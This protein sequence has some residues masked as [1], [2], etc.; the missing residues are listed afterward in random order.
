MTADI[1][2]KVRERIAYDDAD[3]TV[4]E[5]LA[6]CVDCQRWAN[7]LDG[8]RSA[9]AD[10][11]TEHPTDAH[12]VD[13]IALAV[14][15]ATRSRQRRRVAG[16]AS[17][18]AVTV[19]A[20]GVATLASRDSA[21]D[22]LAAAADLY[23]EDGTRFVFEASATVAL[24]ERGTVGDLQPVV[25]R[26]FPVCATEPSPS[27]EFPTGADLGDMVDELL[28]AEPC[29]ALSGLRNE[30]GPRA[31]AAA[32]SLNLQATAAAR[33]IEELEAT[34]GDGD[35]LVRQSAQ[36]AIVE[37]QARLST[38]QE[39]LLELSDAQNESVNQLA[40][41]AQ[42]ANSG[43]PGGFQ[44]AARDSVLALAAVLDNTA[45]TDVTRDAVEWDTLGTGTWM[46]SAVELSGT[47]T[48]DT[49]SATVF[50]SVD[51]DPLALAQVLFSD[52]D[53]LLAVLR[54]APAS[55]GASVRWTVPADLAS[56]QGANPFEAEATFT[57]TGFDRLQL[58]TRRS[59][60]TVI[61]ITF[62]PAR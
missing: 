56:I 21:P 60:G 44:P 33:R 5:H 8:I 10:L 34:T 27:S 19:A 11:G 41:V 31:Q 42:S 59:D 29:V 17:V 26:S 4:N 23:A 49:G 62:I 7:R 51:N 16:W 40:E 22:R 50:D 52:P 57:S 25:L 18:A 32:D 13:Q 61:T 47:A 46:R 12:Q 58:N 43:A 20:A 53:T 15:G 45:S 39:K 2:D 36:S 1:H 28:T 14:H 30:L 55:S 9:A 6:Q 38:A 24:P 35:A 37:A 48:S 3:A 54:G